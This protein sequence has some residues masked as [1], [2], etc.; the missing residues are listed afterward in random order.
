MLL[1]SIVASIA[2][3]L[4]ERDR[5]CRRAAQPQALQALEDPTR[6]RAA[7]RTTIG[8]SSCRR[9]V[10]QQPGAHRR[11]P[12]SRSD[13]ATSVGDMPSSAAFSRSTIER[14]TSAASSSTYQSTSTTP[15]V[16]LEHVLHLP[17]ELDPP[18]R[19]GPV[20]LGDQRLQHRRAGRHLGDLDARAEARGDRQRA[21]ARTRLAIVVA[22][23]ARARPSAAG[24]P[25]CRRRCGPRRRK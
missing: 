10:V 25:G 12:A 14:G 3:Q 11:R 8:T 17:R 22:L 1:S 19:V 24:S 15:A 2:R 4:A 13:R 23:R 18:R 5:A 6:R 21:A 16:R 20:D 9:G 7:S